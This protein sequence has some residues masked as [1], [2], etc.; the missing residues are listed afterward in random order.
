[1]VLATCL[2]IGIIIW[3][4]RFS[5]AVFFESLENEFNWTRTVTSGVF[6]VHMVVGGVFA[7]IGG[8]AL[9]RYGGRI[10]LTVMGVFTGLALI[11]TSQASTPAYLFV[12]YSFLLGI[13]TG[14][15][16]VVVVSIVSRWFTRRRRGLA[17]GIVTSASGVGIMLMTPIA[18]YLISSFGWRMSYFIIGAAGLFITIPC[19]QLIRK[20][21]DEVEKSIFIKRGT[22][23]ESSHNEARMFSLAQAAKTKNFWLFMSMWLLYATALYIIM[24]H[25]VRHTV[26][27]GFTPMQGGSILVVLNSTMIIG[28]PI[29]GRVSDSFGR[30]PAA[31]LAALV[32]AAAMLWL[33]TASS[34]SMLYLFAIVFGFSHGGLGPP[35]TTLISEVF[36]TRHIGAIYGVIEIGWT[37][38][39][40]IG[41]ALAGYVFDIGGNYDFAFLSGMVA[42]LIAAALILL[43]ET[44][45]QSGT[46]QLTE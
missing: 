42:I 22:P 29:M 7:I 14:A 10:V 40:A 12:S 35:I 4:T 20:A 37:T 24:T 13:G 17:I 8:W 26:D 18:T 32:M 28:R 34:L 15:I 6:S 19:A 46:G 30:K 2:A 11:L 27:L 41:P 43:V 1:M 5:F 21:P 16:Y 44:P 31:V 23:A 9:D 39:A 3:G 36:G 33:T 45:K 25:I 38:G